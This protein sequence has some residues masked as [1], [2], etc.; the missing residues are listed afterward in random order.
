MYARRD[1]FFRSCVSLEIQRKATALVGPTKK[2]DIVV[3]V[4]KDTTQK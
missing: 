2:N 4:K 3:Y 1:M